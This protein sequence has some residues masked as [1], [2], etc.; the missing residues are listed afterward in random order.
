MIRKELKSYRKIFTRDSAQRLY[1]FRYKNCENDRCENNIC[2]NNINI[3]NYFSNLNNLTNETIF[4]LI[5]N[6]LRVKIKI[7]NFTTFSFLFCD[8]FAKIEFFIKDRIYLR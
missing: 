8:K 7:V 5:I 6:A 2:N 1:I 4:K 3:K